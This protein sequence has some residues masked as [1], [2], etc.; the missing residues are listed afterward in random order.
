MTCLFLRFWQKGGGF[1]KVWREAEASAS[2]WCI[3]LAAEVIHPSKTAVHPSNC[4]QLQASYFGGLWW[5][6]A[7]DPWHGDQCLPRERQFD[8]DAGYPP[9]KVGRIGDTKY[10]HQCSPL[11]FPGLYIRISQLIWL[12]PYSCRVLD[13]ILLLIWMKH[14]QFGWQDMIVSP[15]RESMLAGRSHG[16]VWEPP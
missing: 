5:L 11:H 4:P 12:M 13:L 15:L 6:S 7:W 8:M 10:C 16:I 3:D 2:P 14:S 9:T 1:E